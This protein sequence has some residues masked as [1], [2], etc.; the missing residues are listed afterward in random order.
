RTGH[1]SVG[2]VGLELRR[3]ERFDGLG[4]AAICERIVTQKLAYKEAVGRLPKELGLTPA[5]LAALFPSLSDRDLRILT[6][7]LESLGLLADPGIRA[8]WEQ[9]IARATDQ[10]AIQ[11]AKN[12]RS[13]ELKEKLAEA[14]DNAVKAA[15]GQATKD[16]DLEIM[17]LIDKSGSME[18]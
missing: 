11:I 5:I 16:E 14:A 4:E 3:A 15:V 2:L 9:A 12:V 1:R 10:R 13:R 17:F 8:R 18:Q 7:S 6:P